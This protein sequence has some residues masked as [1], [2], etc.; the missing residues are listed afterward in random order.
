MK[1]PRFLER[2]TFWLALSNLALGLVVVYLYTANRDIIDAQASQLE[3]VCNTTTTVDI[4]VVIPLLRETNTT[5]EFL[6]PGPYRN[7]LVR[8][9]NNLA[10][11]HESLS[12]TR[13]CDL[14]R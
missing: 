7:R 12:E 4:A 2:A 9:R 6:P 8:F 3:A 10:V 14:V 11:A 5:L 13:P 1:P